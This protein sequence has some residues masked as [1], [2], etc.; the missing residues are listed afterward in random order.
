[1]K[2]WISYISICL[3]TYLLASCFANSV[4]LKAAEVTTSNIVNQTFTSNN[5]WSG[6]LTTNHG[7]GII[8][9]I[10]GGHVE[11][12]NAYSLSFDLGLSEAS[13][14]NGFTSTQ[15][16]EAWFW[17]S[18]DQ[19][20]VMKQIITDSAGNTVNQTK[21]VVGYCTTYNGCGWQSLG[22][23]IFNVGLNSN[24]D[25]T[26]KSRYEFNSTVA[27]NASYSGHHNAADLRYPTLTVTYD[28]NPTPIAVQNILVNDAQELVNNVAQEIKKIEVPVATEPQIKLDIIQTIEVKKE[29]KIETPFVETA[30][31]IK[32]EPAP[33]TTVA[34]EEKKEAPAIIVNPMIEIIPE[35]KQEKPA[36]IAS[37]IIEETK[38]EAQEESNQETKEKPKEEV[39]QETKLTKKE[40]KNV[41]KENEKQPKK[42]VKNKQE[43]EKEVKAKILSKAINKVDLQIKDIT[44]NLETK[45]ILKLAAIENLSVS[46]EAYNQAVFYKP[47]NIYNSQAYTDNRLIYDNVSLVNYIERD[48]INIQNQ[49]LQDIKLEKQKLLIEIRQLKNG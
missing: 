40:V 1:M 33:V 27:G 3:L 21:T 20:V 45:S 15:S 36:D 23:N 11:N 9:G 28:N 18:N 43:K 35:D 34:V 10:D 42:E 47:Q 16:G 5:N 37:S 14:Q 17:N 2:T 32:L 48:P 25:Y 29:I 41:R 38:D 22:N 44:K 24:T 6:Q 4:G 12:T 8:A 30:Q 7:E 19:D 46:L 49:L 26:I 31:Q 13:I 39:K